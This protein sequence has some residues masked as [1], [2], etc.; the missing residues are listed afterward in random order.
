STPK[1]IIPQSQLYSSPPSG[2][3][4]GDGLLGSYYSN[5]TT[6]AGA[7][8]TRVD[9]T[10]NFD[11][12][13][14]SPISGVGSDNFCVRWTGQVQAQFSETYTFY[15]S[16]DDGARLW[17]NNIL[18]VDKWMNQG[19]TEYFATI[20]LTAGQKYDIRME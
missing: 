1:A 18:L 3:G 4:G 17:V 10:V 5:T 2:G 11:W 9:P 19:T 20:T 12:G 7:P 6:F 13:T 14:G 8:V 15:T 16:S